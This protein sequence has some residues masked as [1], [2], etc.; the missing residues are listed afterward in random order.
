MPAKDSLAFD[1]RKAAQITALQVQDIEGAEDGLGAPEQ[2]IVELQ[3]AARGFDPRLPL[4][5]I[6][7]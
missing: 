6:R 3:L 4:D 5:S 2:Q 7:I 1:Q